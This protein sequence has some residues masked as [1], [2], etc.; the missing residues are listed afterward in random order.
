MSSVAARQLEPVDR[1]EGLLSIKH[2]VVVAREQGRRRAD[3]RRKASSRLGLDR[4]LVSLVHQTLPLEIQRDLTADERARVFRGHDSL[5][6]QLGI[7]YDRPANISADE[8]AIL[9]IAVH[10]CAHA[11]V[12]VACGDIVEDVSISPGTLSGMAP[13]WPRDAPMAGVLIARV[14]V[15]LAGE[16]GFA[17]A[18][19]D[20]VTAIM[21]ARGDREEIDELFVRLALSPESEACARAIAGEIVALVLSDG[22]VWRSMTEIAFRLVRTERVDGADFERSLSIPDRIREQVARLISV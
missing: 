2:G 16:F 18:T 15:L 21:S 12:A 14:A 9:G 5:R 6:S 20:T 3:V 8:A 4:L 1:I 13:Y 17:Q 10:E 7:T 11:A 22:D 19:R